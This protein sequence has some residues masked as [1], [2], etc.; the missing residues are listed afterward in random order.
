MVAAPASASAAPRGVFPRATTTPRAVML[1]WFRPSGA[2]VTATRVERRD[3]SSSR[4]RWRT[5]VTVRTTTVRI[6]GLRAGSRYRFRLRFRSDGRAFGK[7]GPSV[8]VRARGRTPEVVTGLRAAADGTAVALDWGAAKDATG[9]RVERVDVLT[10]AVERLGGSAKARSLRD[11]PPVRL[12][13][14]W[15]RYRVVA[16]DGGA[17]ARPSAPVEARAAGSPGYATYW[18][19]GDSYAAGTGLGQPYDDQACSR[20]GRM[21][22]ALIPRDLVPLP[23]FIACSGAKTENVR[24]SRSGGVAQIAGIGG[25]QLDRV[26][27]GLRA[28]PG[29]TLI[30][31]S[32]GG[33]DARFVPQFTRCVT[34]DCTTDRDVETALIR[35]AVRRDLDAT[36]AQIR[37]VAPGA[38]VLVAGYPRL[39]D[40]GPVPLDP[41]FAATLT[42]AERRLAN[43]WA[44]QVDEE[45]AAAARAQGLHPVTDQV[46]AAFVG[47]GAGGPAP[48]INPVEVLDPGTPI[49]L[50][51]Q[52]PATASIHPTVEGNQAYADVVTAALRAF[53]SRVQVR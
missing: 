29:P 15:L 28:R 18:A 53:G 24:L 41:V 10:G 20:S 43:V 51:P 19:L 3:L 37:A 2:G 26:E 23:Q 6:R 34:G 16:T 33:N 4:P 42:Q 21:W 30:T 39:F 49:G 44:T 27:Q 50:V 25:T 11:V 36:F 48:W 13:G 12:A 40:E 35:G 17:E 38:D 9:Y 31:L 45:V 5:A 47:H 46:L 1:A 22:A 7:A 8:L 32:I 14:R 52:L